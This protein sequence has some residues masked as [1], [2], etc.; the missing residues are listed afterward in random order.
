MCLLA[1]VE[2]AK[3]MGDVGV[4]GRENS[5]LHGVFEGQSGHPL[6]IIPVESSFDLHRVHV[7]E[8]RL[9]VGINAGGKVVMGVELRGD[10]EHELQFVATGNDVRRRVHARREA[11]DVV[12]LTCGS[13]GHPHR[14]PLVEIFV[15]MWRTIAWES[16]RAQPADS[17]GVGIGM[18]VFIP[19]VRP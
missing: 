14:D 6:L 8:A 12:V 4:R 18:F 7:R 9:D 19:H 17:I 16:A 5:P 11:R 13:N 1:D 3:A 10:G 15:H 2:D